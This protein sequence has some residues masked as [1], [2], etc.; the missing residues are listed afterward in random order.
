MLWVILMIT[1]YNLRIGFISGGGARLTSTSYKLY[2]AVGEIASVRSQSTSY[3]LYGALMQVTVPGIEECMPKVF[4]LQLRANPLVRK[5]WFTYSLPQPTHVKIQIY[6][7][8]GKLVKT[9]VDKSQAPGI[10][11]VNVATR[12]ELS[13]G[14]YFLRMV[15]AK[16][17]AIRKFIFIR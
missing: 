1:T 13:S 14:I 9:V 12:R 5:I 4:S 8:T 10:Y 2:S 6:D 11:T 16:Y 17:L 3:R 15:T 7:I